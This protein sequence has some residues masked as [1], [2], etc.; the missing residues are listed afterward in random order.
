MDFI[1]DELIKLLKTAG[2]AGEIDLSAPPK[3]EM[4]DLAYACFETA[5]KQGINPAEAAKVLAQKITPTTLVEKIEAIGPY[6]NFHLNT[7]QAAKLILL[8]KE[9][10]QKTGKKIMVEYSQPNTHKEF[11][12]GHLRNACIGAA[13]VKM[14]KET[15]NKVIAANYIGDI[16]AHVAKCLW[17]VKRHKMNDW[18]KENLGSWIGKMYTESVAELEKNPDAKSEIDG[19][20]RKLES[21]DREWSKLWEKTR[22]ASL[23]EFKRIYKLLGNEFDV[24]FFESEEENRGKEMVQEL[25]K[26]GIAKIG[27]GGAVIVD[28]SQYGLDI[29]LLL[30]SD[31]STLY[32]TKDLALAEKKFKKYKIDESVVIID[33]RQVFYFKQLFKTLELAG[34]K[35]KFICLAYEFVRLPE[36]AMSSR[37]GNVVLF[38]DIYNE[39]FSALQSEVAS[40]HNDWKPAKRD[41]TARALAL[42][43]IKF[44]MLKHPIDKVIEF[45]VKEAMSF[46]GYTGPYVLYTIA[47]INSIMKKFGKKV[48]VAEKYLSGLVK[49]EEKNLI[50]KIGQ[51][52]QVIKS[53][54]D[55]FDPSALARYSFDLAK[56]FNDFY[57]K[58]GI[59]NADD[60]GQKTARLILCDR[61]RET[62]GKAA[63]L[64]NIG[65]VE[66]M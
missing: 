35:K 53:A 34:W 23:D 19:V 64:L 2:V 6:V 42:S 63:E 9:K 17:Y 7:A 31:G 46:D 48:P 51:F 39:V 15:G 54:A 3:S 14:L 44:G 10:K 47:R 57:G 33:T 52:N 66:E 61:V 21:R 58:C 45:E 65:T 38:E 59:L 22:K 11:H 60:A 40:R 1:K 41:E 26:K 12:V 5:K 13:V 18:P 4:G 62:L 8:K 20:Q 28:L 24:W 29:F 27:E 32:A 30:K 25:L 50:M 36:G 16:G 37:R 49:G 43:A 56:I 55:G